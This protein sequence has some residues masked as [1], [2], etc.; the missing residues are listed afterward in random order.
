M[1]LG[2][3]EGN[4]TTQR[5]GSKWLFK[6]DTAVGRAR[7]IKRSVQNAKKNAKFLSSPAE[8]VRFTAKSAIRSAKIACVKKR[9]SLF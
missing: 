9:S 6:V 2:S 4:Q 7:C 1:Y 5:G 8:I 3:K